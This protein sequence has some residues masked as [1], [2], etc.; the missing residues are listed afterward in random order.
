MDLDT[1]DGMVERMLPVLESM[2]KQ[3][4]IINKYV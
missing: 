4:W 2:K 3:F 1:K